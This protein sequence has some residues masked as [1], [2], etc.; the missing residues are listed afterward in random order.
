[1]KVIPSDIIPIDE[2]LIDWNSV[3]TAGRKNCRDNGSVSVPLL[4][5]DTKRPPF[6]MLPEV[7]HWPSNKREED[8][9][10]DKYD[11]S[12]K[13]PI[14]EQND[15]NKEVQIAHKNIVTLQS[16]LIKLAFDNSEEWFGKKKSEEVLLD[17]ATKLLYTRT[18]EETLRVKLPRWETKFS[19]GASVFDIE[20]FNQEGE[21]IYRPK[22]ESD[23]HEAYDALGFANL[24]VHDKFF[25]RKGSVAALVKSGGIWISGGKG[26][27][28]TL[29]I[30]QAIVGDIEKPV[31][32][33]C[34]LK[35]K[36][37]TKPEE[38][39]RTPTTFVE[40]SD[41]EATIDTVVEG[42]P[43]DEPS[44]EPSDTVLTNVTA[45][46]KK[47]VVKGK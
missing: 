40:D 12:L 7:E 1:M 11:I 37:K 15:E 8:G 46:K 42:P 6:F 45:P 22:N 44:D 14:E 17:N 18:D 4:K 47:K 30:A 21:V 19:D 3:L 2:E 39:S 32:G 34:M 20:V 26:F 41:E 31:E 43:P 9:K 33:M 35:T 13:F 10:A 25:A 16:F 29:R 36:K 27:G 24:D 23:N 5:K 38:P 28:L